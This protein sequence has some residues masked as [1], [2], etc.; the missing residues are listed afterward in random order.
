MVVGCALASAALT[1]TGDA[2]AATLVGSGVELTL[3]GYNDKATPIFDIGPTPATVG[4][5][6]EYS[7]PATPVPIGVLITSDVDIGARRLTVDYTT[8]RSGVFF[9][10]LFNGFVFRFTGGPRITGVTLDAAFT[11]MGVAEGD[12]T[13]GARTIRLNLAGV[14]FDPSSRLGIDIALTPIPTALPLLAAALGTLGWAAGR[15]SQ[16]R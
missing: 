9:D 7:I 4:V 2:R 5:G 13:F 8:L 1:G 15:P 10:Y 12:V 3:L 6:I 14:A 16:V 11:N